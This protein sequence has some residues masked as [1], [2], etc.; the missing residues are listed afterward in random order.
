MYIKSSHIPFNYTKEVFGGTEYQAK[1]FHKHILKKLPKLNNYFSIIAPGVSP[2]YEFILG[3]PKQIILWLHNSPKQF[4]KEHYDFIKSPEFADKL[5]YII[6]LS[7]S[8]KREIIEQT[9]ISEEKIY[10]IPNGFTPLK[11][12]PR[13]F[14]NPSKIKLINT[15]SPDRGLDVLLNAV[16]KVDEDFRLEI[17]N[18]FNP[19][20]EQVNIPVDSRVK[21]YGKTPKAT[22]LEAYEN[23]HI[24]AYPSTYSETFCVSQAEA[25]SAGLLCVTSDIGALPE[26]SGG[27]TT[28]YPHIEDRLKHA[29]I[30]AEELTKAIKKIKEGTWDPTSQVEYVNNKYC[31]ETIEQQWIKFHELI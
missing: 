7:E 21:F 3:Q 5:K 28:I 1:Y 16:T 24:H 30:F 27:Q 2:N 6:A 20:I 31:W 8:E 14:D 18:S 25:M 19:D 15:S 23:S 29:D 13:K 26:V 11:Y 17:Y 10:L 22:V 4:R 9:G 12:N